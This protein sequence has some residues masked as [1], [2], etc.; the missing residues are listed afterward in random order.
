[1]SIET[2]DREIYTTS[3]AGKLLRVP[4]ATLEWWLEGR[5]GPDQ[6]YPPVLRAEP[7]GSKM[8]T[9]GEFVEAGYLREYRRTH[10][11]PLSH[12]RKFIDLLREHQGVPY[13]LAHY[14][15]YVGEGQKLVI[16]LQE[17]ADLPPELWLFVP[18]NNQIILLPGAEAFLAKVDF[19]KDEAQWAERL[20]P[21]GKQSPVVFD[22]EYS[23]GEPTVRGVRTEVLAELIEAGEAM[24][25]V[26]EE[27][28]LKVAQLKAALSYEFSSVAA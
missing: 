18:V 8:V 17:E 16:K 22:P 3:R 5:S 6:S 13:P 21:N 20:H 4:P 24:D 25:E 23:F 15:P 14:K 19:S 28:G 11:V 27:Y 2:L 1:M 10:K 12:L 26:A 9:W 7:T